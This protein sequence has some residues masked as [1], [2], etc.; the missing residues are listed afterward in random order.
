[1]TDNNAAMEQTPKGNNEGGDDDE[2]IVTK[3][4]D[5]LY[6][7][8]ER[9]YTS[10]NVANLW[11]VQGTTMDLIVDTGIGLWDFPAFLKRHGYISDSKPYMAVATHVHF[12]H[13]GGLHQFSDFGIHEQE[14]DAIIK[15]DDYECVS[16]VTKSEVG[17]LPSE[18]WTPTDYTVLPAN[19]SR[20]LQDGDIIDLGNQKFQVLHLPGHS[21]GSINLWNEATGNLFSGDVIYDDLLIDFLPYSNVSDYVKTFEKLIEMSP[22]VKRVLPGHGEIFDATKLEEIATKYLNDLGIC[23]TCLTSAGSVLVGTFLTGRKM[24]KCC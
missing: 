7:C 3:I 20:I 12:D 4:D 5:G 23:H 9:Y 11:L 6:L 13:S 24:T 19:P 14:S 10:W 21:R 1:M 18:N 22:K 16:L 2:F 15:G 8:K 17:K